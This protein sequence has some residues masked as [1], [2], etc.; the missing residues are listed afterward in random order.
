MMK[1]WIRKRLNAFERKY[2]YDVTYLRE[3]LDLDFGAFM[4]YA[5]ATR[6]GEYRRDVPAAVYWAAKI[7]GVVSEDCGPCTQLSVALALAAGV[8]A[9]ALSAVL[10]DDR[11]RMSPEVRLGVEFARA[12]L[13]HDPAAD[14]LRDEVIRRWGQR[15]VVS[16]AFAIVSARMYPTLKYALGHGKTC[17]RVTVAGQ[18]VTVV[19]SAA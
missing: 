18:P 16:L 4:A 17:E 5:R 8:D 13:A 7:V 14:E 19:K 11:A 12:T 10:A 6:V 1:W 9:A 2:G 3:L 15:A